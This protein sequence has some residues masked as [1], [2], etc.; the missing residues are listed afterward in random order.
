MDG[1]QKLPQRLLAP[2]RAALAEGRAAP[3]LVVA[4][5]GWM[6][7]VAGTDERG[8]PIDVRDP[9]L[10]LLRDAWAPGL[11]EPEPVARRLLGIAAIFGADLAGDARIEEQT[12]A[13]LAALVRDGSRAVV[14]RLPG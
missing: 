14:E 7:Y 13:A 3:H 12:G 10:P 2:L 6:R 8:Q 11:G 4:I 5:A 1:S 9:L